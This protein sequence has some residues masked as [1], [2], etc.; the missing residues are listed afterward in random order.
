MGGD[1]A[2]VAAAQ[3]LAQQNQKMKN[4]YA[5]SVGASALSQLAGGVSAYMAASDEAKLQE[6][7]A[8]LYMEEAYRDAAQK[9]S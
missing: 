1:G 5:V 7:Q 6:A 3:G 8:K 2:R 9:S 4:L